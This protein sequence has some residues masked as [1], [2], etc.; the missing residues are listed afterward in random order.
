MR[1]DHAIEAEECAR[2]LSRAS[3]EPVRVVVRKNDICWLSGSSFECIFMV[4]ST[5]DR[6]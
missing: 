1:A 4:K 2:V 3:A 6:G 5:Q